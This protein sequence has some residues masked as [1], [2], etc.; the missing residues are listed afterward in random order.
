[1]VIFNLY[2]IAN[3]AAFIFRYFFYGVFFENLD[4]IVTNYFATKN[5]I[6]LLHCFERNS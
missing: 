2:N 1:M 6:G 5:N 4:R 3:P